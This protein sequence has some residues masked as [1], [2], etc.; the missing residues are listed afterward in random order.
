MNVVQPRKRQKINAQSSEGKTKR[1][2]KK[3]PFFTNP[4]T[5][6]FKFT[7]K[8]IDN[9]PKLAPYIGIGPHRSNWKTW[10]EAHKHANF[11]REEDGVDV[12]SVIVIDK[13]DYVG[14]PIVLG[15]M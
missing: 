14:G 1:R 6:E 12:K 4:W 13:N 15:K 9:L 3:K 5:V 8:Y 2:R 7:K 10:E 11:L